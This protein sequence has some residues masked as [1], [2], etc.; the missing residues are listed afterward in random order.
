MVRAIPD[1]EIGTLWVAGNPLKLSG[2][3]DDV[4]RR[5][6]PALDADRA[7]ILDWLARMR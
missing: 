2:V 3:P 1:P 5:A 6:P 4:E 7:A